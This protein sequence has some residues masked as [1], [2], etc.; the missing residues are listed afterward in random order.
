[1][2]EFLQS[3][4]QNVRSSWLITVTRV[5]NESSI[6]ELNNHKKINLLYNTNWYIANKMLFSPIMW[7]LYKLSSSV[8]TLFSFIWISKFK[9]TKTLQ[10]ENSG[11]LLHQWNLHKVKMFVFL[12][13]KPVIFAMHKLHGS[14]WGHGGWN[15]LLH[16]FHDSYNILYPEDLVQVLCR[17]WKA[18]GHVSVSYS[19]MVQEIKYFLREFFL[20]NQMEYAGCI[21]SAEHFW[22]KKPHYVSRLQ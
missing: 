15:A 13:G 3:L 21:S 20:I 22:F 8:L 10:Q 12:K 4:D 19:R 11:P 7:G 9:L 18:R 5:I 16:S 2:N 14:N 6:I 1:M 17:E